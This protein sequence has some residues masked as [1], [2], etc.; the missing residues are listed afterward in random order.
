MQDTHIIKRRV[1]ALSFEMKNIAESRLNDTHA[2][3]MRLQVIDENYRYNLAEVIANII[4]HVNFIDES[5]DKFQQTISDY[6][7]QH[8]TALNYQY[9]IDN[10]LIREILGDIVIPSVVIH[11]LTGTNTLDIDADYHNYLNKY[12]NDCKNSKSSITSHNL[13]NILDKFGRNLLSIDLLLEKNII[14]RID[15]HDD[16]EFCTTHYLN[17]LSNEIFAHLTMKQEVQNSLRMTLKAGLCNFDELKNMLSLGNLNSICFAAVELLSNENDLNNSKNEIKKIWFDYNY[18]RNIVPK[19]PDINTNFSSSYDLISFIY[20]SPYWIEDPFLYQSSREKYSSLLDIIICTSSYDFNYNTGEHNYQTLLALIKDLSKPYITYTI[21]NLIQNKYPFIAPYLLVDKDTVSLGLEVIENIR[22]NP[23]VLDVEDVDR[24]SQL[25]HELQIKSDIWLKMFDFVLDQLDEA[26]TINDC[27]QYEHISET[28]TNLANKIFNKIAFHGN[29]D[30]SQHEYFL[31]KYK[32]VISI[33]SAKKFYTS[34][35]TNYTLP[36][37]IYSLLPTLLNKASEYLEEEYKYIRHGYISLSCGSIYHAIELIKLSNTI[38]KSD[39]FYDEMMENKRKLVTTLFDKVEF[40]YTTTSVQVR[41]DRSNEVS[42]TAPKRQVHKVGFELIDWGYFYIELIHS[43]LLAK[44]DDSISKSIIIYDTK[45][46]IYEVN[47]QEQYHKI[48]LYVKSL[49]LAYIHINENLSLFEGII[50]DISYRI[51]EVE[52]LVIK[53]SLKYSKTDLQNDSIDVFEYN[54][55]FQNYNLY[56]QSLKS[57]LY[58]CVNLF[59]ENTG[60]TFI[61]NFFANSS[62]LGRMLNAVNSITNKNIVTLIEPKIDSVDIDEYKESTDWIPEITQ[63]L[64]DATNSKKYWKT[65]AKPLLEAV[66]RHYKQIKTTGKLSVDKNTNDL[67]FEIS[68]MLAFKE[69]NRNEVCSC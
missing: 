68:L 21:Y 9:F 59:D 11:S 28:L 3:T 19:V 61:S 53:H 27:A 14:T 30:N 57:L 15:G 45:E 26:F 39:K 69:N 40:F 51:K 58:K 1:E 60:A 16:F 35:Y 29:G 31:K 46:G 12:Y 41:Q 65:F 64:I 47:N 38:N 8:N 42:Q 66:N 44:F 7:E 23:L 10:C 17:Y 54:Y 49:M 22:I 48:E 18:H 6:N 34:P 36:K 25:K 62:D 37:M 52:S 55:G 32:S 4:I 43:N 63:A 33:I 20:D 2:K 67:L 24:M 5:I 50:P 13:C 56:Y